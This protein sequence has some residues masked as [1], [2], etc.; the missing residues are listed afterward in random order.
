MKQPAETCGSCAHT[1]EDSHSNN[2]KDANKMILADFALNRRTSELAKWN[3]TSSPRWCVEVNSWLVIWV[4][5]HPS[6]DDYVQIGSW[7][8][9]L[10]I[11]GRRRLSPK[12]RVGLH[13]TPEC[14]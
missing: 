3:M 5:G 1:R 14:R 6:T 12:G 9:I 4:P 2:V 7:K 11:N 8:S 13:R 10:D